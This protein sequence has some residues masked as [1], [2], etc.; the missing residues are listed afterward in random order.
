M[1]TIASLRSQKDPSPHDNLRAQFSLPTQVTLQQEITAVLT[2]EGQ[3]ESYVRIC[4][5]GRGDDNS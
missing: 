2:L 1:T 5:A 4:A 3:E